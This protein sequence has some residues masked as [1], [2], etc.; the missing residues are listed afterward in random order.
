MANN[1]NMEIYAANQHIVNKDDDSNCL[2]IIYSGQAAVMKD[3]NIVAT[4]GEKDYFG[5]KSILTKQHRSLDVIAVTETKVYSISTTTFESLLGASFRKSLLIK[6]VEDVLKNVPQ[7]KEITQNCIETIETCITAEDFTSQETCITKSENTND[8]IYIPLVGNLIEETNGKLVLQKRNV[9]FEGKIL[10]GKE[11]P[12][13]KLIADPDCFLVDIDLTVIKQRFGLTFEALVS[14]FAFLSV[15]K[16]IKIF[17]NLSNA[18]LM[19]ISKLAKYRK[20]VNKEVIIKE[21]DIGDELFFVKSGKIDFYSN[22]TYLRSL[23]DKGYFGERSLFLDEARSATAFSIGVS[24]LYSIS[25]DQI[26]ALFDKKQINFFKERLSLQDDKVNLADL[27]FHSVLGSGSYGDVFLVSSQRNSQTYALKTINKYKILKE[28]LTENLESERKVLLQID[29]PFIMKLVKTLKDDMNIYFL[30][31]LIHGKELF[32]VIRDIGVLS[33]DECKFYGAMMM[34]A[35]D[36]LH[37][38]GF[39]YRDM[40][41]ENLLVNG[42]GFIKLIDFGTVKEVTDRCLTILG[43]PHYMAPEVI[44]GEGYSFGVDFWSIGLSLNRSLHV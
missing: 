28:K 2:F 42:E 43:T 20:C 31:E 22:N 21:G 9:M 30:Q 25:K 36:F 32:D 4:L 41:P 17:S 23:T 6:L 19:Q 24:E 29:H 37:S 26:A 27:I 39:V 1:L 12:W 35:V 15:L 44:L 3:G 18:K 34:L 10:N 7:F 16:N 5:E 14:Q 8:H 38:K 33:H 40:K 11:S 13:D